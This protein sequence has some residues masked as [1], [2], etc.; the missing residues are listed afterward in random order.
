M[1]DPTTDQNPP[2]PPVN[3]TVTVNGQ[4][5]MQDLTPANVSTQLTAPAA[6]Q[7]LTE[8]I[9][10][11]NGV[12]PLPP[13]PKESFSEGFHEEANPQFKTDAE[14]N[15]I[16]AEPARRTGAGG[17]LG[18][19]LAGALEG[20]QRGMSA[21]A[22]EGAMGSGAAFS[23]AAKQAIEMRLAMRNRARAIAQ[24]NFQNQ[25]TAR[26]AKIHQQLELA[27]EA[28]ITQNMEFSKEAHPGV[29]RAQKLGNQEAELRIQG[30]NESL[31]Q[32]GLDFRAKMADMG[33]DPTPFM[34][35][36][37]PTFRAH[38]YALA[39]GAEKM[40]QNGGR[41]DG[42][43]VDVYNTS[44]LQSHIL[45]KPETWYSY[46]G[47][48]DKNGAPVPTAHVLSP[49]GK[50]TALDYFN[51]VMGGRAQLVRLQQQVSASMTM[52]QHQAAL[53]EQRAKTAEEQSTAD[54]NEAYASGKLLK[55]GEIM[56]YG[57][58]GK[59]PNAGIQGVVDLIGQ[60]RMD[61]GRAAYLL[62]RNPMMVQI[63]TQKYPDFNPT[64]I[65]GFTKLASDFLEGKTAKQF[66]NGTTALKHMAELKALNTPD[67]LIPLTE[68]K[69]RYTQKVTQLTS[70]LMQFYGIS[71]SDQK[72]KEW[73]QNLTSLLPSKREGSLEELASAM[74]DR[75][76]NWEQE[77]RNGVPSRVFTG[78]NPLKMDGVARNDLNA[79][80][81]N[82][83]Q[84]Y[85]DSMYAMK[86]QGS[87]FPRQVKIS[88]QS[89]NMN[90][91]GTVSVNGHSYKLNSDGKTL[92]L[93]QGQ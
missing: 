8:P 58:G 34:S 44:D 1:P 76:T 14:G 74:G 12:S 69:A 83:A 28:Q 7:T 48:L 4:A 18:R 5:P 78:Q 62:A 63:V 55:P 66:V 45:A 82:F 87:M 33:I 72:V 27:Q 41:G 23:A 80:D 39:H 47:A 73:E 22:P 49:D 84:K 10:P 30:L 36:S 61:V 35:E 21:E 57:L 90:P 26:A 60:G 67:S 50:T 59:D 24:Q 64:M 51:A 53:K 13:P 15:V 54:L 37:D 70:E 86:P 40:I 85:P 20:A 2:I 52:A 79:L 29:L 75:F 89:Y 56:Q 68:A 19:V 3:T 46:D 65:G 77:W 71:E 17:I 11:Q 42:N 16:S 93:V 43:G 38:G 32:N 91:N 6:P 31:M 92:T 9:I 88:G 81:P 25:Q